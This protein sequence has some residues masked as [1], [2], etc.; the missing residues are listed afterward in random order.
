MPLRWCKY[1]G[2]L[3][4]IIVYSRGSRAKSQLSPT[5]RPQ[6]PPSV[7]EPGVTE[8]ISGSGLDLIRGGG[9]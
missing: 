1:F 2:D 9:V 8:G 6:P 5:K 3:V 4:N 7:L